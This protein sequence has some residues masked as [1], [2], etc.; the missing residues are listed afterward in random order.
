MT[1]RPFI[2]PLLHPTHPTPLAS[3]IPQS[4]HPITSRAHPSHTH[5]SCALLHPS[6]PSC[7]AAYISHLLLS[8]GPLVRFFTIVYTL[9]SLPRIRL[10]A[11]SPARFLRPILS[12][13]F[14]MATVAAGATGTSWASI[15]L[16]QNML[17]RKAV[18]QLRFALGGF[19]GGMFAVL[20]RKGGKANA[21]Y[22]ARLSALSA[23]QVGKKRGAWRG[24][25][26]GDLAIVVLGLAILN[27]VIVRDRSRKENSVNSR[28]VRWAME[29]LRGERELGMAAKV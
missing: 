23:W 2:S 19:L 21:L 12:N 7:L 16:F 1:H 14:T 20:D 17:P 22:A 15:C 6:S 9:F 11:S 3:S 28:V 24:T 18:P 13:A 27:G 25:P 26:G 4:I 29:V 5:L 10:L 8:F